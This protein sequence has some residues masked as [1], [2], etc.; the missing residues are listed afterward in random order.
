MDYKK[1]SQWTAEDVETSFDLSLTKTNGHLRHYT[2]VQ[3]ITLTEQEQETLK[4]LQEQL[5]DFVDDWNEEELKMKF[6]AFMIGMANLDGKDYHTFLEREMHF[7]REGRKISG[8]V[9]LIVAEGVRSPRRP[10][11][12]L[13]EYKKERNSANDPLGQV[14]IALLAAQALNNDGLPLYGCYVVGRN[15]FFVVLHGKEY[16]KTLAY[17]ATQDDIA[18]ILRILKHLKV[19]VEARMKKI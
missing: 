18:D 6:I 19:I 15:W 9:D 8:T 7:E 16:A 17:D 3:H 12:S 4:K 11:F 1:F 10:F 14:L 2:D 13:H 5:Q